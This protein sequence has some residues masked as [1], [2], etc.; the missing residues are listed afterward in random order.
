M[1][2]LAERAA[3]A[4]GSERIPVDFIPPMGV[5]VRQ[6]SQLAA[7]VTVLTDRQYSQAPVGAFNSGIGSHIRHSLDHVR[8]F[9]ECV[10]VGSIDYERRARGTDIETSRLAAL[11]A[12]R[13][14]ER[15]ACM[16]M[17]APLDR[18]LRLRVLLTSR[19]PA[20]DVATTLGRELA[21]V[22]SHTTHHNAMIAALAKS[23]G[24]SLPPDFGIAPSTQAY[25]DSVACAP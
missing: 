22:L 10:D 20:T 17:S 8:A 21:F 12:I 23:M 15:R 16:M 4:L 6:L 25:H 24:V 14:L 11:R 7:C 2:A 18:S 5:L 19:G 3:P 1:N 9:L 13:N